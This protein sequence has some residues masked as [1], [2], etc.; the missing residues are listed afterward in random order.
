[1]TALRELQLSAA[2]EHFNAEGAEGAEG[3]EKNSLSLCPPV[4]S[5]PSALI[6]PRLKLNGGPP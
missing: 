5:A 3:T 2:R 6:L 4:S 1:M